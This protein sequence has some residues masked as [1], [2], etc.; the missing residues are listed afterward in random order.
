[1]D[2]QMPDM[3]GYEI[4]RI[5]KSINSKIPIVAQTAYAMPQDREKALHAGC[6]DYLPKPIKPDDLITIIN[7]YI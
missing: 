3:N 7:K 5:I 6:D 2:I 4:T 1:M